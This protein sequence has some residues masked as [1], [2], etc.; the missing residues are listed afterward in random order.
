MSL[1]EIGP[2]TLM[3]E[4]LSAYP[5]AKLG[6]FRRYH[7]G[8][9]A[10]CGYQ[11]TDTVAKVMQE[12]NILDPLDAVIVCIRD[13]EAVDVGLQ[14]LPTVVAATLQPEEDLRLL[15]LQSPEVAD[16]LQRGEKWRL[17]DVRSPEEWETRHIPGAQLLTL[18]LKFEA[19]DS[20]PKDTPIIFYSNTGRHSLEVASYFVAYGSTHVRSMAGGIEAWPGELEASNVP[21]L[22]VEVSAINDQSP[23]S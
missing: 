1:L 17:I 18:G 10:A 12:N 14:I 5:S 8:G 23:G 19:L 22:S 21:P 16:A 3:G 6:L 13:S 2:D 11:P 9:C 7:I 4:I 20:W 15:V